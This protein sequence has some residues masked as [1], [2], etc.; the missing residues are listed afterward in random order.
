M[1]DSSDKIAEQVMALITGRENEGRVQALMRPLLEG[2]LTPEEH[3]REL[4]AMLA[5]EQGDA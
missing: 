1:A 2:Q 4:L 3:R 5:R